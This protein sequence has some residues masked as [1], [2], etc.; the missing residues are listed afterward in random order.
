MVTTGLAS[1]VKRAPWVAAEAGAE[2]QERRSSRIVDAAATSG[3]SD[4]DELRRWRCRWGRRSS[5]AN[6]IAEG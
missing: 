5:L 1:R 6:A 3:S 2:K 4:D